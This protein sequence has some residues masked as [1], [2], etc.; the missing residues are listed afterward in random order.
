RVVPV[1]VGD[2][3]LLEATLRQAAPRL[4]YLVPDHHNP[5]GLSLPEADR[6][7]LVALVCATRTPLVIDE[8]MAELHFDGGPPTP[9]AAF[10]P[11]GDTALIAG[12][13]SKGFWGGL[14]IGWI[15]A[16]PAT[17]VRLLAARGTLDLA[18][19]VI[20]QLVAAELLRQADEILPRQRA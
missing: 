11:A 16:A 17:I 5:T 8:A 15:R 1:P 2:T 3:D 13:M 19:P 6:E 9:L 7:R 18:S 10:D 20:E 4:A 14:R 12:S